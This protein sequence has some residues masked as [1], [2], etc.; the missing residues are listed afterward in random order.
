[1]QSVV[2]D[3]SSVIA[4]MVRVQ[5]CEE[6]ETAITMPTPLLGDCKPAQ[7]AAEA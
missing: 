3:R 5:L 4:V 7:G 1:M 2:D 6:I